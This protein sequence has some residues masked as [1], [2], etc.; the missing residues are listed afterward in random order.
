MRY[1]VILLLIFPALV[2]AGQGG[3]YVRAYI[4]EWFKAHGYNN[5][6][7]TENGVYLDFLDITLNGEIYSVNE[8]RKGEFYSAE[9]QLSIIFSNGRKLDDFAAG[10]GE[11]PEGA[12]LD[13]LNNFCITTLHP[14][15]A[16]VVEKDDPHVRKEVWKIPTDRNIFLAD[17]GLR[18]E[19]VEKQHLDNIERLV[20]EM[21][22]NLNLTDETH[23]VKVVV[24][25]VSGKIDTA[26]LTVDGSYVEKISNEIAAYSWPASKEFYMVKLFFVIGKT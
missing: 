22:S 9:T 15:Y 13:S 17:W 1:I 14:V 19:T 2:N 3:E 4:G 20:S 16:E 25:N 5:Y 7:I 8:L 12:F 11:S 24:T 21:L 18:G 23:W 10:A 6:S 26:V